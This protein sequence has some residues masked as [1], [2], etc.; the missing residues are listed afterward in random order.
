MKPSRQYNRNG[1]RQYGRQYGSTLQ[2]LCRNSHKT[3]VATDERFERSMLPWI[4]GY[5]WLLYRKKKLTTLEQNLQHALSTVNGQQM[6][7]CRP[8]IVM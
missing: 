5:S 4:G 1:T 8:D 7:R 2:A 6:L 3:P